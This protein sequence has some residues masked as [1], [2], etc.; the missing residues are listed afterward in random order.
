MVIRNVRRFLKKYRRSLKKYRRSLKKYRR[1]LKKYRRSLKKY[2]RSL[3]ADDR[4]AFCLARREYRN[5]LKKKEQKQNCCCWTNW[6]HQWKI[7]KTFGNLYI[8]YHPKE[9]PSIIIFLCIVGSKHFRALLQKEVD[10]DF[11]DENAVQDNESS[12]QRKFS[13]SPKFPR[14]KSC[15]HSESWRMKNNFF[16]FFFFFFFKAV[17]PDGIIGEMLKNSRNSVTNFFVTFLMLCLRKIFFQLNG[18]NLS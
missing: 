11:D 8:S 4:G 18:L 2:R 16:F 6:F 12:R 9:S 13:Q 17:G 14:K 3:V 5:S 1:S 7:L 10:F 15:L